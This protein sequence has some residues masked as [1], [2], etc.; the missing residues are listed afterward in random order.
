MTITTIFLPYCVSVCMLKY[1]PFQTKINQNGT[2][3]NYAGKKNHHLFKDNGYCSC[4]YIY[5]IKEN[6]TS[7]M[8]KTIVL[9]SSYPF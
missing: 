2:L 9:N 8:F 5:V 3:H 7:V 6:R 1:I 4:L